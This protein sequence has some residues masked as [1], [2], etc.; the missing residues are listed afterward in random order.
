M[1]A[2]ITL[3]TRIQDSLRNQAIYKTSVSAMATLREQLYDTVSRIL[4]TISTDPEFTRIYMR[5][6]KQK[7]G[8]AS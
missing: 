8:Y 4:S 6:L 1:S 5:P 7:L 3:P 2:P